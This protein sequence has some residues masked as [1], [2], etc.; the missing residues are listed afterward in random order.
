MQVYLDAFHFHSGRM[1]QQMEVHHYCAPLNE[2]FI[3]CAL[4]DGNGEGA[5]LVGV[6]YVISEKLFKTLPGEE[7]KMW[8][9]HVYE[10]MSG[11]LISPDLSES[12]EKDLMK[13]IV[14]TYGKT[15]HTWPTDHWAGAL[16]LGIPALMMGFIAEGQADPAL[17]EKRDRR[18]GISTESKRR[19]RTD[20]K[21]P[22]V[23]TGADGWQTGQAI[24]LEQRTI[25]AK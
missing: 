19:A 14:S 11:Q 4:F 9:S 12:A 21:A 23:Q 18:F 20:I 17:V 10:V 3:Q 22:Q 7:K 13:N 25:P 24:Q 6:E 5:R 16:P 2:D 1:D 15:W 8:H